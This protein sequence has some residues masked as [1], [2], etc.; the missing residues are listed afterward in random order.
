M[1]IEHQNHGSLERQPS[2][3]HGRPTPFHTE[4]ESCPLISVI[5]PVRNE[6]RF[7]AQTI[8]QLVHQ[9]YPVGQFEILVVDGRSTDD[10]CEIV[11]SLAA[12]HPNVKLLDNPRLLS[13][14]A[15]NI[16]IEQAQGDVI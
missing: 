1:E 9:D 10:T 2:T 7:I 16:G 15:R 8:E 11:R 3:R 5:V 14:A 12:I 4:R 13:S 6:A